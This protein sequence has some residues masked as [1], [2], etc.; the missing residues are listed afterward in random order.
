MHSVL[1]TVTA[2]SLS[3]PLTL[4]YYPSRTI[5]PCWGACTVA[6]TMSTQ[7]SSQS[8][9]LRLSLSSLLALAFA[10]AQGQ[11]MSQ[12]SDFAVLSPSML[13]RQ[14]TLA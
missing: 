14:F 9:I 4:T 3:P 1:P 5:P 10:G 6:P 12:Q 11:S 13:S 7:L 2:A 8:V